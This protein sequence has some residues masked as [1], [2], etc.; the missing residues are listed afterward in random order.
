MRKIG[1]FEVACF[2]NKVPFVE[3]KK[4]TTAAKNNKM[5]KNHSESSPR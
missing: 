3:R 4:I 5:S 2:L 1:T